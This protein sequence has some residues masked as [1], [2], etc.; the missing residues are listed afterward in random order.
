MGAGS[1]AS[2]P[3][4]RESDCRWR[5]LSSG[6]LIAGACL[7]RSRML[8]SPHTLGV[9]LPARP[10]PT[11]LWWAEPAPWEKGIP[12]DSL[13]PAPPLHSLAWAS[14]LGPGLRTDTHPSAKHGVG[15]EGLPQLWPGVP[16]RERIKSGWDD[17]GCGG[18]GT[19][20]RGP[21]AGA[22]LASHRGVAGRSKREQ[23]APL[24]SSAGA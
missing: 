23:G 7:L 2:P 13:A 22:G 19:K 14:P 8:P 11:S 1:Q 12:S 9:P 21:L 15:R 6:S 20:T 17:W 3:S 24:S 4:P 10:H 16:A 5:L 18:A